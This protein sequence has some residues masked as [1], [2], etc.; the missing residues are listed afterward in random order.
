MSLALR[1]IVL[2][3]AASAVLLLALALP[4]IAQATFPGQTGLLVFHLTTDQPGSAVTGGLYAIGPGDEQPRQLTTNPYDVDPSF[5]PSGDELVFDRNNSR[6]NG[7]FT[8]DLASGQTKRLTNLKSDFEPAFGPHGAIVFCHSFDDNTPDLALRTADGRV[9]RLTSSPGRDSAPIFTPNGKRIVFARKPHK[10]GRPEMLYS[11][12][13]DGSGLQALHA[14]PRG[15]YSFDISPS[16][17]RLAFGVF[18]DESSERL[19]SAVWTTRLDGSGLGV[20]AKNA[21]WPAYSPSGTVFAYTNDQGLWQRRADGHGKPTLLYA[22]D[23]S[24]PYEGNLATEP[25]WQPL[26]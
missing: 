26:P 4:G 24:R 5:A 8:L 25:A 12:R 6:E 16:G 19:T 21:F 11:I 18:T 3:L 13:P 2:A 9:R 14:L 1:K 20:L 15:A 23:H 10:S 7:I 17:R 22:A